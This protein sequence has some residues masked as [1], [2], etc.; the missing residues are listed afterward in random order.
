[1]TD[2]NIQSLVAFGIVTVLVGLG[3]VAKIMIGRSKS[4]KDRTSTTGDL[5]L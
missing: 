5:F 1:M 3:L 4:A 2:P